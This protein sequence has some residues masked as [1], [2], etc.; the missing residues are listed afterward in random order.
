[1]TNHFSDY[2]IAGAPNG[3][4][5]DGS[6]LL[7]ADVGS[8]AAQFDGAGIVAVSEDVKDEIGG[9]LREGTLKF[10]LGGSKLAGEQLNQVLEK[11]LKGSGSKVLADFETRFTNRGLEYVVG[12]QAAGGLRDLSLREALES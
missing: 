12:T 5:N 9:L 11:E 7:K 3:F 10:V 1:M 4:T 6:L 8:S 2:V